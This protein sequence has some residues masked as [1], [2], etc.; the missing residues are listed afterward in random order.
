MKQIL[1]RLISAICFCALLFF[2]IGRVTYV[3]SDKSRGT[4]AEDYYQ[5]GRNTFDVIFA[6]PS[7]TQYAIQP[8]QLWEEFG[9]VSY[10]LGTSAQTVAQ[11]YYLVKEA[12]QLHHPKLVVLD[13]GTE[14]SEKKVN[15]K[16]HLHFMSDGMPITSK[17]KWE[18][19]RDLA[20]TDILE[21]I[22]PIYTYHTRWKEL[23]KN[24]FLPDS[25]EHVLGAV[26]GVVRGDG[27]ALVENPI[28][29][30]YQISG[31]SK[32]YIEKLIRL[33]RST[34]TELLMFTTPTLY[35]GKTITQE[36]YDNR[37]GAYYA[38]AE[39][40][41]SYDVPFL[42]YFTRGAELGMDKETDSGDGHHLNIW[43]ARKFTSFI[44]NY[45][46]SRY[47]LEDHRQDPRY[48]P[49][50]AALAAS[51][52]LMTGRLLRS[53]Y[54]FRTY[55]DLLEDARKE[56]EKY[57]V[58]MALCGD[59]SGAFSAADAGIIMQAGT[60]QSLCHY[61]SHSYIAVLDEGKVLYES[62]IRSP[63]LEEEKK[64]Q[65]GDILIEA[66]SSVSGENTEIRVN[67]AVY[68]ADRSCLRIVV[69][70][71]ETGAVDDHAYLTLGRT[72]HSIAHPQ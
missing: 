4:L 34:G 51:R 44:G 38:L 27:P 14:S 62:D 11:E 36:A 64:L 52:A 41:S 66:T 30:S 72:D 19:M 46:S 12:I 53:A 59:V 40:L 48:E 18:M 5:Y 37:K 8:M 15:S 1:K 60:E 63:A 47:H 42:N 24:D 6:G 10:N 58:V 65:V 49:M 70:N 16:E 55:F 35:E 57:I 45:I 9:I 7:T 22:L 25:K 43:G 21:F 2:L 71:K 20:G 61:G 26:T 67:G 32:Y 3:L 68:A 13:G 54:S 29:T 69:I 39:L 56:E 17:V 33:C 31:W 50:N 23:T 28:D